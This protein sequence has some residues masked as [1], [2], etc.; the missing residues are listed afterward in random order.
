MAKSTRYKVRCR[1]CNEEFQNDYAQRHTKA[2]H[3]DLHQTG[4]CVPTIILMED[5]Q[6]QRTMDFFI[7]RG[8]CSASKKRRLHVE[9]S[10]ETDNSDDSAEL[11]GENLLI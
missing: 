11:S 4:R 2:K 9:E 6:Q 1:L 10:Q 7:T 5:S 3:K 8:S